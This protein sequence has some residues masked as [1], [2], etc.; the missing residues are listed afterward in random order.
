MV[1]SLSRCA[2]VSVLQLRVPGRFSGDRAGH[3][4]G[5]AAAGGAGGSRIYS[6]SPYGEPL[7]QP[8]S[9]SP[10]GEPLLQL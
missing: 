4:K 1:W 2:A 6:C 3:P 5:A 9:C 10:Y 8:Y 7:L